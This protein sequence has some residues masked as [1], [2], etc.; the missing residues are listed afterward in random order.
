MK[1][2]RRIERLARYRPKLQ[3]IPLTSLMDVFTILVFFLLVNSGS[4]ELLRPPGEM[5]LPESVVEAKP[6]ETVVI[7]VNTEEVIV[8]GEPVVRVADILAN[9]GG[10]IEPIMARLAD[11]QSRVIGV[12]T[13]A[14]AQ[15]LE[16][17]ILADKSIPFAVV[18]QVMSSCTA[19]GYERISLAVVQKETAT[20]DA[21]EITQI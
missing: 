11:L 2:S 10:D 20:R 12:R 4:T 16:V 7:Y 15:S 19:Q 17:T 3:T 8:Q 5:V 18:K 9:G 14:V 21:T 6:R 13:Q 1:T